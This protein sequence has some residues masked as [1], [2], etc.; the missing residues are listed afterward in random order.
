MP[1][2]A[3]TSAAALNPRLITAVRPG[4]CSLLAAAAAE[5]AGRAGE[6]REDDVTFA[7]ERARDVPGTPGGLFAEDGAMNERQYHGGRGEDN[8]AASCRKA[9]WPVREAARELGEAL[10]ARAR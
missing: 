6:M 10:A 3:T 1:P 4:S 7:M 5:V 9:G 2:T 8:A